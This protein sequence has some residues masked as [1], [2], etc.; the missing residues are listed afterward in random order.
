MS[1]MI[2][3]GD[4][5]RQ[6]MKIA[7]NLLSDTVKV[8][9]GPKGKNVIIDSNYMNPFITN[10][11]VTIAKEVCSDDEVINAILTIAKESS[12]KTNEE[13]GDGTTT[14]LVLLKSIFNLSLE[15]INEGVNPIILKKELNIALD[16]IVLEIK[17]ETIKIDIR[18]IGKVATL[19]SGDQIVGRL[20]EQAYQKIGKNGLIILEESENNEIETEIV[21]GLASESELISSYML[22]NTKLDV[23]NNCYI[24]ITNQK[25]EDISLLNNLLNEIIFLNKSLF[26]ICDDMSDE[27][28][29]TLTLNRHQNILDVVALK[30][31]EYGD[32]K[33]ELL[34]DIAT[35]TG[36]KFIN[37]N[38]KDNLE[39]IKITDLG[40]AKHINITKQNFV[41]INGNGNKVLIK[42]RKNTIIAEM[43]KASLF[44]KEN[45][46][47]RLA[48]FEKGIA[49]IKVGANSKTEMIDKKMRMNDALS[50]CKNA[51]KSGVVIGGGIT[52]LKIIKKLKNDKSVA[53]QILLQSLFAPFK[54]I[55][56]NVGESSEK[57]YQE[58]LHSNFN[59]GYNALTGKYVDMLDDGIIDPASVA[60]NALI[61]ATSIASMLIT[62]E[63]IVINAND[64]RNIKE[65][66]DNVI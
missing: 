26:I 23:L 12:I 13:V 10:D 35:L 9:L 20:I 56:E 24:L 60:I 51:L 19:S 25:I 11:G 38:Y 53:M 64:K 1:K 15:K 59:K 32:N 44:E 58:L 62:T 21:K 66:I 49:I 65:E 22:K 27:A 4:Y 16:K 63:S 57:I 43:K 47:K 46:E 55:V 17:K 28:S 40:F 5:L 14:A 48:S 34:E 6:K 29:E 45:L 42:E 50:A 18:D 31:M 54:E 2:I 36:G 8:T 7:I 61:N 3:S 30:L 41:I 39:N 33:I 37:L 52:Y